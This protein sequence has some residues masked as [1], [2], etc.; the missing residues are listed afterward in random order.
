[1]DRRT[2]ILVLLFFIP[3][4]HLTLATPAPLIRGDAYIV[5]NADSGRVLAEKNST[6]PRPVASTQKLLTALLVSSIEN[7]EKGVEIKEED[8]AVTPTKLYLKKG[9]KYTRYSLLK[10]MLLR[11]YNDAAAAL[12]RDI[13]GSEEDFAKKMNDVAMY[14]GAEN[15]N[16]KNSSGLPAPEQY[17]TARDIAIIARAALFDPLIKEIVRTKSWNFK[18]AS[19]ETVLVKNTNRLLENYRFCTGMKTGYTKAAGNCLVATAETPEGRFVA[20]ILGS[21]R[22]AIWSDMEKL[23]RWASGG[24]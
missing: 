7:L 11:S 10:A 4:L 15:S 13:A 20:V 19:G 18:K 3:A 1:M 22:P 8:T 16:F 14:L 5:V 12:A 24:G 9:E 23:L 2:K 17:S 6:T 21:S